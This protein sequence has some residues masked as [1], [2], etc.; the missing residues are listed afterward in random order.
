MEQHLSP[1]LLFLLCAG[2]ESV[3]LIPLDDLL[4]DPEL[5]HAAQSD[6]AHNN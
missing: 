4:V 3:A 1:K 5:H 6:P 2:T